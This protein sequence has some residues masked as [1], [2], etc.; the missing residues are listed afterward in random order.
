[1]A[2]A[3]WVAPDLEFKNRILGLGGHDLTSCYQCGTCSVVCP[4]STEEDPF[5]RKE[6][7]WVQWGL[8]ARLLADPTVWTCHQCAI[9][10]TYC[11]RDAKPADMMAA[12]RDYSITHYAVPGFMGE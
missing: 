5:P 3:E 10:N 6:M 1:M 2:T 11:P 8:K 7:V 4:I 9:C 12:L